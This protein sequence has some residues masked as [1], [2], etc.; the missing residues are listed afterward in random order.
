MTTA[1]KT[2]SRVCCTAI[3]LSLVM[4]PCPASPAS[5]PDVVAKVQSGT[6]LI[7]ARNRS[8]THFGTGFFV[9]S[10]QVVVTALHVVEGAR[11]I[12]VAIPKTF[13]TSDALLLSASP[14]WDIAVL[15]VAWPDEIDYPGLRLS[16]DRKLL[17]VGSE[18]AY[19]GYGFGL[20]ES[21][22][23]VLSTVRGIVSSHVPFG[24]ETLYHL[25]GLV[26]QGL[27]GG[28]LYLPESGE[29]VGVVTRHFGPPAAGMGMGG[30][31]PGSVIADIVKGLRK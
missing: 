5:F 3:L 15:R 1:M 2:A 8:E 29:V 22:L 24:K 19:T 18:V 23:G 21:L 30:A 16:K 9:E 4:S 25:S 10:S 27:S 31:V 11:R 7:E 17:P 20:D 6:V 14:K 13:L 26:T 12:R 28:P